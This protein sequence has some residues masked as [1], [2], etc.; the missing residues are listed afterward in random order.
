MRVSRVR[1]TV[2]RM[3]AAVA[4]AALTLML[5]A[6]VVRDRRRSRYL[7]LAAFHE[8]EGSRNGAML[9]MKG[10]PTGMWMRFDPARNSYIIVGPE[11]VEYRAQMKRK[12]E[13]AAAHPWLSFEPDPPIPHGKRPSRL[14]R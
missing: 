8:K 5:V 7:R 10:R 13:Y 12:Y 11:E 2:R 14:G 3:M 1:F 9:D 4:I 6:G